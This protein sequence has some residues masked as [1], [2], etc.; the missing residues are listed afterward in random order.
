MAQYFEIHP[1]H[2]QS[3]LVRKA[4]DILRDDG[5]VVYPTDASYAFGC[6]IGAADAVERIRRLRRLED[7]HLFTLVCRDIGEVSTYVKIANEVFR[8]L[9]SYTPGPY[10]FILPATR[11]VPRRLQHPKRKTVGMRIPD[12]PIVRALIEELGE[13]LLS[14][15]AQ[16]PEDDAPMTDP[17]SMRERLEKQVDLIID[18]GPGSIETTTVID[19]VE[20]VPVVARE[21]KG[22][23]PAAAR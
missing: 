5:V 8:F 11:E 17:V 19:L 21:G 4:V 16:L 20:G 12:T 14:T 15:T 2:P 9:R 6:R 23:L 3:R 1:T 7:G 10:T 18:G 22:E 13:P